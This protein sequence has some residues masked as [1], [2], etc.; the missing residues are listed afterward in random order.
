MTRSRIAIGLV[1]LAVIAFWLWRRNKPI[2]TQA[3]SPHT[4]ED[5]P[6]PPPIRD[7]TLRHTPPPP[8]AMVAGQALPP[9]I[10]EVTVEKPEVCEG[11]E[12][13]VTVRAHTV[14]HKDDAFLHYTIGGSTG[15]RVPVLG[16]RNPNLRAASEV[17]VFG[18]NNMV[19]TVPVPPFVVKECRVP[20][21]LVL[22]HRINPNTESEMSF[23]AH[24]VEVGA[25]EPF[26]PVRWRWDFGQGTSVETT[27]PV[28]LHDFDPRPQDTLYAQRFIT[29]VAIAA[30][31]ERV[32]GRESL[33]LLN[34]DYESMA[35]KGVVRL[36]FTLTPRFP[37]LASDGTVTQ[38]VRIWHG[39]SQPVDIET[40]HLLRQ[41][42][43]GA[44]PPSEVN[45]Q[46]LLGTSRIPREGIE[47]NAALD[48]HSEPGVFARTYDLAGWS[49]DGYPARG[50]FSIM[51][52]TA[53]PTRENSHPVAD[54]ELKAKILKARELLG[55]QFVT[56]EDLWQLQRQ[57]AFANLAPA[58]VGE[59]PPGPS[60]PK[61]IRDEQSEAQARR[62]EGIPSPAPPPTPEASRSPDP[63]QR[64]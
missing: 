61:P 17:S 12:N 64:K 21:R 10:D 29:C 19:T 13:L 2:Q 25:T 23:T 41:M 51:L 47:I 43:G 56:D 45:V 31:G 54:P 55:K 15:D 35:Y 36:R 22:E 63:K 50:A 27:Q 60:P 34:P 7:P 48:T 1:L 46:Q 30:D 26:K 14:E 57:G 49:S 62:A 8:P 11:E 24:I 40:V 44:A 59:V 53:M 38:R 52:P 9:I 18:R 16:S 3:S 42:E 37:E 33:Q 6:A 32:T 58:P 28:A 5:N 39:A 4:T 20:R